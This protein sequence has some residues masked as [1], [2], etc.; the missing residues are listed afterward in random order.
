MKHVKVL[1]EETKGQIR[2]VRQDAMK[3]TKDLFVAKEIGEDIHKRNEEDIES[4]IKKANVKI[5]ELV[6]QKGEEVMK[7]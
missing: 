5:D 4:I 2:R 7:V 1:G 3:D 6:E